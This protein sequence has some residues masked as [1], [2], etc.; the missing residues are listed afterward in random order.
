[1]VDISLCQVLALLMWTLNLTLPN[2]VR[3]GIPET[4]LQKT[5]EKCPLLKG[6]V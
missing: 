4:Q 3:L 5:C 6:S 2:N 1:M